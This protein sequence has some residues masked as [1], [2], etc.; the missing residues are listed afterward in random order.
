MKL[1]T[2][3]DRGSLILSANRALWGE[4]SSAVRAVFIR[5]DG[6]DVHIQ[7]IVDGPISDEDYS[8]ISIVGTEIAADFPMHGIK[9][10]GV[11]LDAPTPVPRTEGW[12]LVFL[13]RE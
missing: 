10:S 4:I 11:R 2:P 12:H 8:S 1:A 5:E 3:I 13:R 7:F 9:E 6:N